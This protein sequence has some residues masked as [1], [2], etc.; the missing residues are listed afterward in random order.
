MYPLTQHFCPRYISEQL[1]DIPLEDRDENI[2]GIFI[3][4]NA[5]WHLK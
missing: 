1:S 4:W 5:I 2:F 3:Q